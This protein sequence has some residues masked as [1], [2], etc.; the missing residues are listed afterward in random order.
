MPDRYKIRPDLKFFG[1]FIII[2][3]SEHDIQSGN[4]FRGELN[5]YFYKYTVIIRYNL[6]STGIESALYETQKNQIFFLR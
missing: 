5:S 1:I 2:I 3:N 4:L 6:Y